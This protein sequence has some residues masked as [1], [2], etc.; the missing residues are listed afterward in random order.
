MCDA[1]RGQ[2]ACRDG[3]RKVRGTRPFREHSCMHIAHKLRPK[4][5]RQVSS[6]PMLEVDLD[7][8][9]QDLLFHRVAHRG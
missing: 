9:V 4:L 8:D 5:H 2:P 3:S 1:L 6:T 7:A